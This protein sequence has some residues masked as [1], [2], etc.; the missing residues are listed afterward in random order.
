MPEDTNDREKSWNGMRIATYVMAALVIIGVG[1][2]LSGGEPEGETAL[3]T[4]SLSWRE[5]A[6]AWWSGTDF[7]PFEDQDDA[8][9]AVDEDSE[10]VL[11]TNADTA[12]KRVGTPTPVKP[13]PVAVAAPPSTA[14]SGTTT[15]ATTAK[16]DDKKAKAAKRPIEIFQVSDKDT[17]EIAGKP[18]VAITL[19]T[20]TLAGEELIYIRGASPG[21]LTLKEGAAPEFGWVVTA[22]EQPVDLSQIREAATHDELHPLRLAN[23][24]EA[25]CHRTGPI[26]C[27]PKPAQLAK[28]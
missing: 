25:W 4:S 15:V 5:R 13:P 16:A 2:A 14:T 27:Q 3:E 17:F 7:W 21:Q 24:E 23:G 9:V 19:K 10:D 1:V 6:S 26:S 11:D 18:A 28:K 8:V 22:P 12:P 20:E